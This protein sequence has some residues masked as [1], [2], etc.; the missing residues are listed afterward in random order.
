MTTVAAHW[1]QREH[2]SHDVLPWLDPYPLPRTHLTPGLAY[3]DGN[4]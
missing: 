3:I 2:Q 1:G 4:S